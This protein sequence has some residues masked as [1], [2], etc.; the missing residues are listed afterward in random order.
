M[1]QA[2]VVPVG[3]AVVP[4]ADPVDPFG[5]GGDVGGVAVGPPHPDRR[6]TPRRG[7]ELDRAALPA[8]GDDQRGAV[9]GPDRQ[10]EDRPELVRRR[11]PG[12]GRPGGGVE[13]HHAALAAEVE[14]VAGD[15]DRPPVA[16]HRHVVDDAGHAVLRGR[17]GVADEAAAGVLGQRP[18][19]TQRSGGGVDGGD[20]RLL[21]D[22]VGLAV[23]AD[24]EPPEAAPEVEGVA[25]RGPW[26][27]RRESTLGGLKVGDL[28]GG[29]DVEEGDPPGRGAPDAG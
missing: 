28:G 11:L 21:L 5:G 24:V 10:A 8:G 12:G 16:G 14:E 4:V 1:L 17:A 6:G 20:L 27:A 25:V 7:E 26:P 13:G 2:G 15:V 22:H 19:G 9:A 23:D 18:S 3:D 29:G